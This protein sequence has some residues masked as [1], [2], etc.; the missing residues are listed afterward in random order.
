MDLRE[1]LERE[2]RQRERGDEADGVSDELHRAHQKRTATKLLS[3]TLT[4][5]PS[6][7]SIA[8]IVSRRLEGISRMET[9][10]VVRL[11]SV[12]ATCRRSMTPKSE[13][14]KSALTRGSPSCRAR[15]IQR[16]QAQRRPA[17]GRHRAT[18]RSTGCFGEE[19]PSSADSAEPGSCLMLLQREAPALGSCL[20]PV[21]R[22]APALGRPA[23]EA[24]MQTARAAV[25]AVP[26]LRAAEHFAAAASSDQAVAASIARQDAAIQRASTR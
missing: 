21:Q 22:E 26:T 2:G 9:S 25:G 14:R 10:T 6:A 5:N 16:A 23:A 24:P 1:D 8:A 7:R 13:R 12:A 20:M 4:L 17:R 15:C 18:A 19:F 3:Q 11:P